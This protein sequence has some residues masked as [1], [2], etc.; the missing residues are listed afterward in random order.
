MLWEIEVRPSS[1]EADREAARVISAGRDLGITTV[2]DVHASRSFLIETDAGSDRVAETAG[3]LLV[4]SLVE[5]H[6]IR[7][8]DGSVDSPTD[9]GNQ[10]LNVL[11]KPGV[12]DNVAQSTLKA[13]EELGLP[14][15]A[16]ATCRKY[17]INSDATATDLTRL[18]AQRVLA[19]D[20]IEHIVEGPLAI[21]SIALGSDYT[22][23][24]QNVALRDMDDDALQRQSRDGQLYLSLEEMRTIRDHFTSLDATPQT[25]S[26]RRSHRP[27]ANTV[28]TRRS[29]AGSTTGTN[30]PNGTST[31]CSRRPSSK[32]QR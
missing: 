30:P 4:D 16:V 31:R 29:A 10:L 12:T 15:E 23:Q 14:V 6:S 11:F 5:D 13:L 24:L 22:F 3:T 21:D 7:S 20:A 8:L 2:R 1:N 27:G 25:S 28:R 17:R 26:S 18:W 9:N 19:N 32:R